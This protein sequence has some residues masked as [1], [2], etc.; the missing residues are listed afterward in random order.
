M[1]HLSECEFLLLWCSFSHIIHINL[2]L[3]IIPE[4]TIPLH[5][6]EALFL[7]IFYYLIFAT[8]T[9]YWHVSKNPEQRK[10]EMQHFRI[11]ISK[12]YNIKFLPKI[13]WSDQ[14]D[15]FLHK[16]VNLLK[17]TYKLIFLKITSY[18]LSPVIRLK[19]RNSSCIVVTSEV[20][21]SGP[22]RGAWA[23]PVRRLMSE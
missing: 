14:W 8:L 19:S 17:F 12:R 20:L 13:L 7:H 18:F 23:F 16:C 3:S 10:C 4:F 21:L 15:N 22:H 6:G 11:Y 2:K 9:F 5:C 1:Y